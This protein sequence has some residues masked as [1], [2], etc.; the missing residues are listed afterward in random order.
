[1]ILPLG[2]V[3]TVTFSISKITLVFE[4]PS[5]VHPSPKNKNFYVTA[6][7]TCVL[8][9]N[10]SQIVSFPDIRRIL[11]PLSIISHIL[12][13]ELYSKE[14]VHNHNELRMTSWI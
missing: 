3:N 1:M 2:A 10:G 14:H 12:S 9:E 6:V 5:D 8:A 11:L 7:W 4:V 13:D